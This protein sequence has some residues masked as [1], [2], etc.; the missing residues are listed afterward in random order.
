MTKKKAINTS[1]K[2]K[3]AIA[4]ASLTAGNGLVT[5]NGVQ[6]E[7]YGTFLTRSRILE[8]I[9]LAGEDAQGFD[10]RITV[11]G[12]GPVGQ[13]DA[14]RLAIGRALVEH[15]PALKTVFLD[16]DR[17]LLIADVRRKE[18]AKPNHHG[19]ARAAVQK[20]YR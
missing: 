16:Y 9:T 19:Q 15:K 2:R 7:H 20:S 13:A 5:I 6:L 1:G 11:R 12:G 3:R 14:A 10:V 8:P 4:R 17:Q 18:S